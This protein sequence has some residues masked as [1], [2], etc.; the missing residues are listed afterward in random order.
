V[1]I[2]IAGALATVLLAAGGEAVRRIVA[3][4]G[5]DAATRSLRQL[6]TERLVRGQDIQFFQRRIERDPTGSLDLIRLGALHL[7]RFHEAGEEADLTAAEATARR[8]L[9]NRP[10]RN[11][12]AWQLL[13]S[14]LFGQ[15][16]F[17]EAG[18]AAEQLVALDPENALFRVILGEVLL[19][20]GEYPRADSLFRPLLPR[21]HE[22]AIAPRYARWLELRGRVGEARRLLEAARRELIGRGDAIPTQQLAWYEL[23]LGELAL[24]HGAL[25]EARRYL[26][27]GIALV[28]D[29]WRLLAARGRLAL[30]MRDARLAVALGDSS[31]TRHLDPATL[32]AVGDGWLALGD[33]ATAEGYY[34]AMEAAT[35]APRGGFHRA[36]YL[37]LLD[38]GRR[39]PEVL[40]AVREDLVT[41]KDVYGYDLLAWAL[42]KNGRVTEARA[43]MTRALAWG[44][45]DP[46]LH[47]HAAAIEAAP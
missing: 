28:P 16:R 35:Q 41:R 46:Q 21:R 37:A 12:A 29:D 27:A 6:A 31:L 20:L 25:G 7:Q 39:L 10:E 11:E 8:S 19:E 43:V 42:F 26:D 30:A 23:R 32:A 18:R 47:A 34:R 5:H 22:A 24:R 15:H 3:D 33:T 36:W 2:L 45:E 4:D 1:R 40:A 9:A 14:A 13:A 44:T 17:V 38:R